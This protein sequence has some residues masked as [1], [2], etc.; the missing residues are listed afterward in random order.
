M[1][2]PE[3]QEID[4]ELERTVRRRAVALTQWMGR[5]GVQKPE[6]A[7][8][9]GIS[10]RTLGAWTGGWRKDRL[11]RKEI[12]R[13]AYRADRVEQEAIVAMLGVVGAGVSV[14]ELQNLFPKASRRE[15]T[16]I[17]EG[18][19]DD[20]TARHQKVVMALR[21]RRPG[22]VWAM[23]FTDPP[24]PIDGRYPKILVVRD[25]ASGYQIL[26]LPS[27]EATAEVVQKALVPV[28]NEHGA[29]LVLKSDNGSHFTAHEIRDL[30]G[31]QGIF[32]LVSPP[33]TPAYNG[34]VEAG[35]GSLKTRA[36]FE[37]A[38]HER[39]DGEWICDDIEK[40]R[41]RANDEGR[42]RGFEGDS[43][44]LMW[45]ERSRV[46]FLEREEFRQHV[47]RRE[48]EARS[49]RGCLPGMPVF[50]REQNSIDRV[51]IS[52]A[53]VALGYLSYRRRRIPVRISDL[54]RRKIS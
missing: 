40:A 31:K 27:P 34:A 42:P 51:S 5:C 26:A 21:W 25:L 46:S 28:F 48:L 7:E 2:G 19:R 10:P 54:K 1:R 30:I 6:V 45:Y 3:A 29:P 35:I 41:L 24:R 15:L 53:C 4:R 32:H 36:H 9:L 8:V 18:Y 11:K 52:R 12:G 50:P 14:R 23:D 13:R 37:S 33:G 17:L 43:P 20:W 16:A 22:S 38:R 47:A 44:A 39:P 49:E